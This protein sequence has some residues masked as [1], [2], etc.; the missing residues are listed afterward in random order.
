MKGRYQLGKPGIKNSRMALP[1][2]FT[3]TGVAM[4]R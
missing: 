3:A 2:T 4:I 1:L